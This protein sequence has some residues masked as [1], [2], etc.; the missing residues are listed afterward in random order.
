MTFVDG[1]EADMKLSPSLCSS[2]EEP[3]C[4]AEKNHH[5]QNAGRSFQVGH[6]GNRV[7]FFMAEGV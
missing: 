4:C 3:V 1:A 5:R 2:R 6:T 7:V